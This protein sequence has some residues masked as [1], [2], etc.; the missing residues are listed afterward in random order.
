MD[1]RIAPFYILGIGMAKKSK[2]CALPLPDDVAVLHGPTEDGNGAR[3][4]RL[5]RG[6]LFAGEVHPVVEGKPIDQGE[7]VRLKPLAEG[8]P[9]CEVEVVHAPEPRPRPESRAH[10]PARVATDSYRR[11]WGA[12]FGS[13][14]AR[15]NELPN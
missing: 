9:V 5:R 13:P 1:S 14:R 10:G 8:S 11:N 15:A 3:M 6:E 2:R 7:L 4:T 12:I